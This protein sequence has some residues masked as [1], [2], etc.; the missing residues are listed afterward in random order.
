MSRRS[1][2]GQFAHIEK[3]TGEWL[4]ERRHVCSGDKKDRSLTK[5]VRNWEK[6]EARKEIAEALY[7]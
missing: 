7:L 6:V 4:G 3:I 1:R 2:H 5:V